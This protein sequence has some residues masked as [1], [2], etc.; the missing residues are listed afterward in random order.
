MQTERQTSKHGLN[1]TQI[2]A[3]LKALGYF[4]PGSKVLV[5]RD[6]AVEQVSDGGIII[7]ESTQ[8]KPLK[9][10]ILALGT[11][12]QKDPAAYDMDGV[13]DVAP[14]SLRATFSKYE[15]H[16]EIVT[17]LDGDIVPVEFMT[18]ADLYLL[19]VDQGKEASEQDEN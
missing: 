10:T 16:V 19:W 15:G 2:A 9:G 8:K 13:T 12:I 17:L 18:A 5:L 7:G 1:A 4:V 6:L 3:Q 14:G 11:G